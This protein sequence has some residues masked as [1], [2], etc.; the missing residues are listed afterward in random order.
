MIV[1]NLNTD[2][3][4]RIGAFFWPHRGKIAVAL[5]CSLVVGASSGATAYLVKPMLDD[6]FISGD[7]KMLLLMPLALLLLYGSKGICRYYQGVLMTQSG[8]SVVLKLRTDLMRNIESREMSFFDRNQTGTLMAILMSDVANMQR[9]IPSVI[10]LV[11]QGISAVGLLFVLFS[12]NWKL[13]MLGTFLLPPIA[14]FIKKMGTRMKDHARNTAVAGGVMNSLV[15]ESFTGIEVVKVFCAEEKEA[16]RFNR[17]ATGIYNLIMRLTRLNNFTPAMIELIGAAAAGIIVWYGGTEVV[18]QKTT[19]GEFFS[20]MTALFLVYEPVKALGSLNNEIQLALVSADR[21]FGIMDQPIA[22]SEIGGDRRLE[23]PITGI[24]FENVHFSYMAHREKVLHGINFTADKG[25]LTALVGES[26]SGKSTVLKLLPRLYEPTEGRITING[27][28]ISEYK[29]ESLRSEIAVV[30][31]NTYLFDDTIL[32]N[33]LMGRP[34]ATFEE[35]VEAAKAASA[36]NYI[37]SMPDGYETH[38]G[39]RGN[40][41][42]GGQKQRLAIARAI[43]KN[44]PIL[45]LDEATSSLDSESE[46]EIQEALNKLMEGRT[47]FVIAHRLS[48]IRHADQILFMRNGVIEERGRHDELFAMGGGYARLCRLQYGESAE[49]K[50]GD[51]LTTQ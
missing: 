33:I 40:L 3:L 50:G 27:I 36:H 25:M 41:L 8:E 37:M 19:P 39:E 7:Q 11:R 13:A 45:I 44:A 32:K 34:G 47:T 28:D 38:V 49:T 2:I 23:T 24:A 31:Q 26:G 10:N 4:R 1:K 42:S 22:A 14:F 18:G 30:T 9:A 6:V 15:L 17:N 20:F 21:V 48:T 29:A 51:P 16:E 12:M 35:V 43:L 5:F 46:R